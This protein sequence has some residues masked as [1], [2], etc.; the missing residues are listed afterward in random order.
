VPTR[1]STPGF[2]ASL[3]ADCEQIAVGEKY[4]PWPL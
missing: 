4:R 2:R 1:N 3:P